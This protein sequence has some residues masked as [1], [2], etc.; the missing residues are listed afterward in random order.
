M[1]RKILGG[2]LVGVSAILFAASLVGVILAWAFNAP[3]TNE[4]LD[5]LNQIDLELQQAQTTL[6]N[7]KTELERS[8]RIVNAADEA[9]N[10][11]T[12]ND[13]EAFFEDV[14]TTLND[15]LL[16]ELET[17]R[18]RLISARDTLENLRATIFG[19]NIVPFIQISIPDKTLT[20]LIDSAEALEAEIGD[21]SRLADQASTL[22]NDASFLLGGDFSETRDS[23]EIFLGEIDVYQRKVTGWREQIAD[24]TDSIP[25]WLDLASF[26]L[27][28][29]LLWFA[30]SQL[31]LIL[32]G[33]SVWRGENPLGVLRKPSVEA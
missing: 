26:S 27:T 24:W 22:L 6:R 17:A 10:K 18:E 29:F 16:P 14:Q 13:P 7:S 25:A 11:F 30:F 4:A 31:G 2:S 28:V 23:L 33:L 9:L 12:A 20:D 1:A 8:L 5:R 15:E 19:L 3:V 21:V 32:H